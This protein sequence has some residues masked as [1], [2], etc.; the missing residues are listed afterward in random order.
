MTAEKVYDLIIIGA[1]PVGLEAAL[2]ATKCDLDFLLLEKN[3][4]CSALKEWGFVRMFSPA[5][6]NFSPLGSKTLGLSAD[7]SL[8]TGQQLK[9][10]YFDRL[11]SLDSIANRIVTG[12]SANKISRRSLLK[13][14]L[15][16]DENRARVPFLIYGQHEDGTEKYYS[17]RSVID[18]TGV[19]NCPNYLGPGGL[20]A[21]GEIENRSRI[22]YHLRQIDSDESQS[23]HEHLMIVGSGYSACTMLAQVNDLTGDGSPMTAEWVATNNGQSPVTEFADD[24]LPERARLAR[25]ANEISR[26]ANRSIEF[27]PGRWVQTIENGGNNGRAIITLVNDKGETSKSEVD[28]L[29]AMIGYRPDRSLYEELQVH[30]CYA[31]AGPMKLAA[32]LLGSDSSDCLAPLEGSDDLYNNPEPRFFIIGSKSYGRNSNYLIGKGHEQIQAV[33]KQITG[34][35]NLNLYSLQ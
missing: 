11:A 33:F 21:I 30:E 24:P 12:F 28:H 18:S 23:N 15:V 10:R 19:Y 17:A 26:G 14:A 22:S 2:Y 6:M 35:R 31:S 9:E 34:D 25:L 13:G 3:E 4:P 32:H 7:D 5:A 20:P 16:G 27:R 8:W 1:G 29:Y